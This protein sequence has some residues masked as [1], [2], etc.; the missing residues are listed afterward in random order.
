M[1]ETKTK[2]CC[3]DAR[4]G[5]F[6]PV[7]GTRLTDNNF[8]GQGARH[9][10]YEIEQFDYELRNRADAYRNYEQESKAKLEELRKN[11]EE[12]SEKRKKLGEAFA[13][14]KKNNIGVDPW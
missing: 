5:P 2:S 11:W 7:C 13:H 12:A 14:A 4:P 9:L 1:N 8:I 6:C 3:G 10:Q